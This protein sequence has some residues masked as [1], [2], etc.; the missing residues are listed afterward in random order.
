MIIL[1][2]RFRYDYDAIEYL[3]LYT[4]FPESDPECVAPEFSVER[5]TKE[6]GEGDEK[7]M[8]LVRLI[9]RDENDAALKTT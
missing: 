2:A 4:G 8:E 7:H 5:I 3:A 1:E 9:I 6:F